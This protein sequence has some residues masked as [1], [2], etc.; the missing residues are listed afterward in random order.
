MP[1]LPDK[2]AK[3]EN[4]KEIP[5]KDIL[6]QHIETKTV[7]VSPMPMYCGHLGFHEAG[8]GEEPDEKLQW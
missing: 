1:R 2:N 8:H 7:A 3:D 5:T 4:G 6:L